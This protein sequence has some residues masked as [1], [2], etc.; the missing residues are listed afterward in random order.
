MACM[1][2]STYLC[3]QLMTSNA[4]CKDLSNCMFVSTFC[5]V[6]TVLIAS[7]RSTCCGVWNTKALAEEEF[8]CQAVKATESEYLFYK[9]K[10]VMRL[11]FYSGMLP[12][13]CT[14]SA[15]ERRD[16]R[17]V[18]TAS[19]SARSASTVSAS[20]VVYFCSKNKTEACVRPAAHL[21]MTL[22]QS[23]TRCM[24]ASSNINQTLS[25]IRTNAK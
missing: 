7:T 4:R 10:G 24:L 6:R 3:F 23:P 15:A 5:T 1:L 8:C 22:A 12:N 11:Y 16:S 2:T 9:N 18:A 19:T 14:S 21:A 20:M 25:G 13:S 17:Q